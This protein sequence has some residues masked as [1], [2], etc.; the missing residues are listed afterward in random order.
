M[1][2]TENRRADRNTRVVR[3]SYFRSTIYLGCGVTA[4][5]VINGDLAT[6]GDML[7]EVTRSVM[8]EQVEYLLGGDAKFDFT[9]QVSRTATMDHEDSKVSVTLTFQPLTKPSLSPSKVTGR[10]MVA[11][12]L[13]HIVTTTLAGITTRTCVEQSLG[14]SP[15]SVM[16]VDLSGLS[17]LLTD[18]GATMPGSRESRT[19]SFR[20]MPRYGDN[21]F[22]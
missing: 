22:W 18:L 5:L 20:D 8:S 15:V 17:S 21:K 19:G 13:Q 4:R 14:S 9:E 1:T 6:D 7:L 12:Y 2:T 16:K 10:A 11:H 3:S